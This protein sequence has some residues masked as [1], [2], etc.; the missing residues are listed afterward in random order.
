LS[1]IAKKRDFDFDFAMMPPIS[2]QAR[3]NGP[4][5]LICPPSRGRFATLADAYFGTLADRAMR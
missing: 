3:E 1:A 2:G 4:T 5:L